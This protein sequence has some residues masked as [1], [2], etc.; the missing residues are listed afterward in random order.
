VRLHPHPP[1]P[2][3]THKYTVHVSMF[4][5]YNESVRD[6]LNSDERDREESMCSTMSYGS[7]ASSVGG[8]SGRFK[9]LDIRRSVES[10]TFVDGLTRLELRLDGSDDLEGVFAAGFARR[11]TGSTTMNERS[12]RSHMVVLVEVQHSK[13]IITGS[14]ATLAPPVSAK[15]Y[16]V[17]L[18]GSERIHAYDKVPERLRESQV[19]PPMSPDVCCCTSCVAIASR[20]KVQYCAFFCC[21]HQPRCVLD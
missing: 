20:E 17:D 6:L 3:A 13:V 16:L 15:M 14:G 2:R 9:P 7:N 10:G 5:I 19:R 12:S 8:V 4:E 1:P 21:E 18:A 11:S